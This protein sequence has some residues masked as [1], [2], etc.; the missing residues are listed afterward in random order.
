VIKDLVSDAVGMPSIYA[1][2]GIPGA[3]LDEL[4]RLWL[5]G[6]VDLP[7]YRSV[8]R[9]LQRLKERQDLLEQGRWLFGRLPKALP[10]EAERDGSYAIHELFLIKE[11]LFYYG[12]LQLWSSREGLFDKALPDLSD[13]FARL[14]PEGSATPAFK[15]GPA[16]SKGL[17]KISSRRLDL[18]NLLREA[19]QSHFETATKKLK[20]STLGHEFIVP[21]SDK[22]LCQKLGRSQHFVLVSESVANLRFK[23]ADAALSLKLLTRLHKLDQLSQQEE[24]R[25]T[26]A[27]SACLKT[28]QPRL[29]KAFKALDR[30][31]LTF[32]LAE[33]GCRHACVVPSL[34]GN[35][36]RIKAAVNLPLKLHLES[37]GRRYQ[38]IDL[39]FEPGA[40]LITGPNMGGKSCALQTLGQLVRMSQLRLPLPCVEARLPLFDNIWLNQDESSRGADLSAFGR[41]L[42]SF[43]QALQMPGTSLLL[44]DEFARGTNPSEGEALLCAILKYLHQSG[45]IT[46]S[47]THFTAPALMK[48]LAQFA[49]TGPD[50]RDQ[51]AGGLTPEERLRLLSRRMDYRLHRLARGK[52]PPHSAISIA[53]LLG[54]PDAILDLLDEEIMP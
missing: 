15:L 9:L 25:V 42:V 43:T 18:E 46:V 37:Q 14:D 10:L 34:G 5:R 8:D 13:I 51:D 1:L 29:Q 22:E 26:Q 6:E 16:F 52:V 23:L 44:L 7:S 17:A 53:R 28:R 11:F 2:V 32:M 19:R 50:L 24:E 47:A 20:I 40:N 48:E 33:F 21:R 35:K 36:I 49:I 3:Y 39:E 12:K 27:L 31:A 41:E 54:L 30:A 4:K 38:P 45:H